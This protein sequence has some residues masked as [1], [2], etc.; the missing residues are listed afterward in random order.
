LVSGR[1]YKQE[2]GDKEEKEGKYYI[3]DDVGM[4]DFN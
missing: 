2:S 4:I 1:R 3:I